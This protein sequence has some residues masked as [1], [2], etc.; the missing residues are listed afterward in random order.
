MDSIIKKFFGDI[1]VDT[2]K[3]CW[4]VDFLIRNIV[5]KMPLTILSLT[6]KITY[7]FEY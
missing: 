6:I 4:I 2:I 3:V 1:F 7:R 5:R